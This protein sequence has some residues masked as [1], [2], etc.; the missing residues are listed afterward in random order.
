M[1]N[2]QLIGTLKYVDSKKGF[3]DAMFCKNSEPNS[4]IRLEFK[5]RELEL[6]NVGFKNQYAIYKN[7]EVQN[8]KV[9]IQA[10]QIRTTQS[11]KPVMRVESIQSA[12]D[13]YNKIKQ[14]TEAIQSVKDKH[15]ACVETLQNSVTL[16]FNAQ[17]QALEE[18]EKVAKSLQSVKEFLKMVSSVAH[19]GTLMIEILDDGTENYGYILDTAYSPQP[20]RFYAK[21]LA[22][23]SFQVTAF[24]EQ[25]R[26]KRKEQQDE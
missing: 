8:I 22:T 9:V 26:S 21:D 6:G 16:S 3:I 15:L 1:S 4:S 10:T 2:Q 14:E 25:M 19:K 18:A 12:K 11:G 7:Y 13:Y 5:D 24:G 17:K 23:L 20:K